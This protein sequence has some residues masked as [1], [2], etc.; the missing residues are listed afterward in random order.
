MYSDLIVKVCSWKDN[1]MLRNIIEIYLVCYVYLE[2]SLGWYVCCLYCKKF[3]VNYIVGF[4]LKKKIKFVC[5]F[6][7]RVC[8]ELM[9]CSKKKLRFLD[10]KEFFEI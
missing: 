1:V 10:F 4:F 6:L 5:N 7:F 8:D 2:V 9:I 3:C